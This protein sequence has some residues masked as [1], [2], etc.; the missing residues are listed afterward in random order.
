MIVCLSYQV[1][2]NNLKYLF[3]IL[4]RF[5]ASHHQPR[6]RNKIETSET[7]SVLLCL[8]YLANKES[9]RQI[10]DRFNVSMSSAYRVL[11]RVISFICDLR[12]EYIKWPDNNGK[13]QS[14]EEFQKKQGFNGVI[15][16]IDGSHIRINRPRHDEE[17]Y[18]NRKGY[19]SLLLQGVVDER[20][21][22]I[23]VFCGEPGSLH[24]ARLLR[25]SE[26]FQKALNDPTLFGEYYLLGDSAYPALQWLIPPF[27]DNG[28]LTEEQ[29]QFNFRHS[30]TRMI[31]EHVFGLLKNRFRRLGHF[32]NLGISL[33]VKCIMAACVL[34]NI[35]I[36]EKDINI[37]DNDI[38]NDPHDVDGI[39]EECTETEDVQNSGPPNVKDRRDKVF[40]QMFKTKN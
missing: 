36:L 17:V 40:K 11:V 39:P 35:C 37:M 13:R 26:L 32:E 34:H 25:K 21:M 24:D 15:G 20:K 29:R 12:Q 14:S 27:R 19:H 31:V 4:E 8:W 33:I 22:F 6:N 28:N 30:S 9:F 10:S 5:K 7:K 2:Y 16:C 38:N 23:D 18:V 3:C 1:C